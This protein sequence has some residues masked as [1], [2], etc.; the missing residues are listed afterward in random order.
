MT[1]AGQLAA[2][3][4]ECEWRSG[5]SRAYYGAFHKALGVADA[6]LPPSPYVMGEH[7]K[8]TERLKAHSNKGKS[9]AYVLIDLKR[10]RTHADYHLSLS[11]TQK[12]AVDHVAACNAFVPKADAFA[13]YVK[14]NP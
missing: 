13:A 11:F 1:L 10:V 3:P 12:Q 5:S 6:H 9:V 7:E 2:G 14:A 8:L 4:T